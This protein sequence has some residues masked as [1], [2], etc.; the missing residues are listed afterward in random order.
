M[1]KRKSILGE[2]QPAEEEMKDAVL[3]GKVAE[4]VHR[5]A[6]EAIPGLYFC[7]ISFY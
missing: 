1:R 7:R 6:L 5:Q 2:S 4:V 3:E